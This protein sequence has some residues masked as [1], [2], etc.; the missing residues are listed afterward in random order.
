MQ[1][2]VRREETFL[3]E[4]GGQN[5]APCERASVLD[6]KGRGSSVVRAGSPSLPEE[7]RPLQLVAR[8]Q[9]SR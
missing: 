5:G 9:G 2:A 7:S 6:R 1:G 4:D 8:T 3:M